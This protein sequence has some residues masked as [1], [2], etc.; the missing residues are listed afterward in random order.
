MKRHVSNKLSASTLVLAASI[1][2]P[3]G[4]APVFG[5]DQPD[6]IFSS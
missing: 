2:T 3:A 1:F 6:H 4:S 5:T